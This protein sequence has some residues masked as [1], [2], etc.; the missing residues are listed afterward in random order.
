MTNKSEPP[1]RPNT[2]HLKSNTIVHVKFSGKNR[3]L[4]VFVRSKHF[5]TDTYLRMIH[6][7]LGFPVLPKTRSRNW[8]FAHLHIDSK[9]TKKIHE[10]VVY[11]QKK[12]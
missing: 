4:S 6:N 1:P 8:C 3:A 10:C 11:W 2:S 12:S 7:N 9:M 5:V